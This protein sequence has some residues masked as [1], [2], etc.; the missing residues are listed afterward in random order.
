MLTAINNA[1]VISKKSSKT[2]KLFVLQIAFFFIK[3]CWNNF[4]FLPYDLAIASIISSHM[5]TVRQ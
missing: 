4:V 5:I 3:I 1:M 2:I